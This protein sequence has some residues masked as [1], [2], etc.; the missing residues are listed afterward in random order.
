MRFIYEVI[1]G[2]IAIPN[3]IKETMLIKKSIS[4]LKVMVKVLKIG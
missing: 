1:L 3:F 4:L 2:P